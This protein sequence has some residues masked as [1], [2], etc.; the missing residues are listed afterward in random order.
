MEH[1]L[2]HRAYKGEAPLRDFWE[3]QFIIMNDKLSEE[4]DHFKNLPLMLIY[5]QWKLLN[6]WSIGS[7]P[8]A[9]V[10]RR[11]VNMTKHAY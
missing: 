9:L 5:I 11:F 3:R 1:W 2:T 10:L 8:V 7:N 4:F 6:F